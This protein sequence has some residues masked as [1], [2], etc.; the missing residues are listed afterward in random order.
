MKK[1]IALVLALA[2]LFCLTGCAGEEKTGSSLQEKL[3]GVQTPGTT[4]TDTDAQDKT[5]TPSSDK[6]P[7]SDKTPSSDKA[8]A[9]GNTD[10]QTDK[11]D[12]D[13][14]EK[15]A[16][17]GGYDNF[18]GI[19][20]S[21]QQMD[22]VTTVLQIYPFADML[23]LEY[24]SW[25]DGY[26]YDTW[27]EEF[28][29]DPDIEE[30]G[31]Y[32]SVTGMSQCFSAMNGTG[33][34]WKMA[35]PRTIV[36]LEDGVEVQGLWNETAFYTRDD[37]RKGV[38]ES[39]DYQFP[40][41]GTNGEDETDAPIGKWESDDGFLSIYLEIREDNTMR[42]IYKSRHMAVSV[43]DG[44]WVM[45]SSTGNLEC[46]LERIGGG[47]TPYFPSFWFDEDGEGL[48]LMDTAC[49]MAG[50]FDEGLYLWPAEED[51]EWTFDYPMSWMM[52]TYAECMSEADAFCD[53]NGEWMYY[54]YYVP[55]LLLDSYENPGTAG[56]INEEIYTRFAAV[57]EDGLTQAWQEKAPVYHTVN[58]GASNYTG[59]E[60]LVVFAISD[61]EEDTCCAYY[62]DRERDVRLSTSEMLEYLGISTQNYLDT[63]RTAAGTYFDSEYSYMS[64][65]E[66]QESS[67][68]EGRAWTISD[69]QINL[70]MPLFVNEAG[71][72]MAIARISSLANGGWYYAAL[73]LNFD[74]VG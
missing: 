51:E 29:P 70:D 60:M 25:M 35:E 8:P 21:D 6:K 55:Q 59:I 24:S 36:I 30:D 43:F 13:T 4:D 53:E 9:K 52:G 33:S 1:T 2:L 15:T 22:E 3:N 44:E 42:C 46:C 14:P 10:K 71:D 58:Y 11:Q 28:W 63:V 73:N 38:H 41:P 18:A 64:Q 27:C 74:S 31:Q 49:D 65:S 32:E 54:S 57:A 17:E 67:F 47:P 48:L 72:M 19:Y 37:D 69:E 61:T 12:T 50:L 39:I 62:Y 68:D 34:Y 45:D 23:L 40:E 56:E 26:L 7:A 16:S 20:V 5:E 66:R